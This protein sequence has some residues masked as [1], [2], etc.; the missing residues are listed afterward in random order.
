[1]IVRN[2]TWTKVYQGHV[3]GNMEIDI[4]QTHDGGY[5]FCGGR[6]NSQGLLDL[7]II[8]TDGN[9]NVTSTFNIP[10]LHQREKL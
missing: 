9:G 7:L 5:I 10:T 3:S 2:T 4:K 8:K 6:L 1:M